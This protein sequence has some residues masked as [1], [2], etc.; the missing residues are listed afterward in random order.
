M[1][2]TQK[3]SDGEIVLPLAEERLVITRNSVDREH[4]RVTTRVS[5][6]EEHASAELFHDLI[7][8]ER[9]PVG[10]HVDAM[11]EVRHEGDL[12]IV[13]V[14]R[15]VLVKRLFVVEE[16]HLRRTRQT[17]RFE[18]AVV[19]RSTEAIVERQDLTKKEKDQ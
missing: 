3:T 17:E 4:V 14:V 11:P 7:E 18:Q 5:E 12:L 15:E 13:P 2:P 19:L 8:V 6:H 10:E 1:S 9:V 16:V